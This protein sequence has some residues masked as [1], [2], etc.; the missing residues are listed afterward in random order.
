MKKIMISMAFAATLFVSCHNENLETSSSANKGVVTNNGSM[1]KISELPLIPEFAKPIEKEGE[2]RKFALIKNDGTKLNFELISN[3]A[4]LFGRMRTFIGTVNTRGQNKEKAIMIVGKNGFDLFYTDQNQDYRLKGNQDLNIGL[5][6]GNLGINPN[7]RKQ[8]LALAQKKGLDG[9]HLL[10]EAN[11]KPVDDDKRYEIAVEKSNYYSLINVTA[12]LQKKGSGKNYGKCNVNSFP[13]PPS[14]KSY[15][16]NSGSLRSYNIEIAFIESGFDFDSSYAA[17]L[18][19]LK[20]VDLGFE[21]ILPNVTQYPG[22]PNNPDF[23]LS[24]EDELNYN[25]AFSKVYS[26]SEQLN[27]LTNWIET[28][29][30]HSPGKVVR[31]ALYERTWDSSTWGLGTL[32]L[33]WVNQYRYSGSIQNSGRKRSSLIVCDDYSTT[34]AHECGH[35]LGATHVES[36][37]DV[38]YKNA[39]YIHSHYDATNISNI[40]GSLTY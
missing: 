23:P 33:A 1:Y 36:S 31:V 3:K 4:T 12:T 5:Q 37:S 16:K 9:G 40:K 6:K 25:N 8:F 20:S 21:K 15:S 29:K 26:A 10:H 14:E 39:N 17:L 18:T 35:N 7:H 13:F 28:T 32:G 30:P 34:L 11:K 19:S 24:V 22:R 2:V 27:K 38:M